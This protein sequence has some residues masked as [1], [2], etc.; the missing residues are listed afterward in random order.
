[1]E[2]MEY[3]KLVEDRAKML[4][5]NFQKTDIY[6]ILT[7]YFSK[8]E[9]FTQRGYNLNKGLLVVGDVGT[10]KTEAFNVF[11]ELLRSSNRFFQVASCRQIIRDYTNEGAKVLNKYGRD[12]KHT[13]YFDDL[14]LEE[15]NVKM[16]GN[17]AN[18]MSEIMLDRYESFKREG[19]KTFATSNLGAK[20][21]GEIYGERMRDRMREMFNFIEVKGESFRK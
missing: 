2:T 11:R 18:V 16:Y 10:G 19:I 20:E 13:V 14:G 6:D 4:I 9:K 3:Y 15:V 8:S 5:P 7:E 21:F 17:N 12:S 1:M